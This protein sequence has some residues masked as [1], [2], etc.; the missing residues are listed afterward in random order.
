MGKNARTKQRRKH[1]E[2]GESSSPTDESRNARRPTETATGKEA[3]TG[4]SMRFAYIQ[5]LFIVFLLFLLV[6][7]YENDPNFG[8]DFRDTFSY[9]L[10]PMALMAIGTTGLVLSIGW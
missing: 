6:F 2:L 5:T 1:K 3:S 9:Y 10:S 8:T 7:A 4:H